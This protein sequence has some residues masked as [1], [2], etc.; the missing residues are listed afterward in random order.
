MMSV[1]TS[2]EMDSLLEG[3]HYSSSG[4]YREERGTREDLDEFDFKRINSR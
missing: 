4:R 1:Y 3:D 2:E